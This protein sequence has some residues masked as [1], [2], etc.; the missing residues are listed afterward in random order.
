MEQGGLARAVASNKSD[1]LASFEVVGQPFDE[2]AVAVGAFD[3]VQFNNLAAESLWNDR[4][5][6]GSSWMRLAASLSGLGNGRVGFCFW[7]CAEGVAGTHSS[8]RFM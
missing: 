3:F 1:A 7:W 8:S 6:Q 5:V 4:K 2:H